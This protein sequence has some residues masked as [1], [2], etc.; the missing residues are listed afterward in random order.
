MSNGNCTYKVV[1]YVGGIESH[2]RRV[3]YTTSKESNAEKFLNEYL[4][5]NPDVCKAYIERSF[6]RKDRRSAKRFRDEY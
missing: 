4:K 3:I 1:I 6:S 5:R 2:D